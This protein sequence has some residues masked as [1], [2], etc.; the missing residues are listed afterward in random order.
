MNIIKK[1]KNWD[2]KRK[3]NEEIESIRNNYIDLLLKSDLKYDEI[4]A[5]FDERNSKIDEIQK[6]Y[7]SKMYK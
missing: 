4:T 3:K 7:E 6:K 2:N 1:F 5:L